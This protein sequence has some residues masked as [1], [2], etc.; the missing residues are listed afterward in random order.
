MIRYKGAAAE[1]YGVRG[2]GRRARELADKGN[3]MQVLY[4]ET[5]RAASAAG[6]AARNGRIENRHL[7]D[8]HGMSVD[9]AMRTL[10][11]YVQARPP[12]PARPWGVERGGPV[13]GSW[14][15]SSAPK[16]KTAAAGLCAALRARAAPPPTSDACRA[17]AVLPPNHV[18]AQALAQLPARVML[19]VI[20]GKGSHSAGNVPLIRGAALHYLRDSGLGHRVVDDNWGAIHVWLGGG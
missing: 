7:V 15:G 17:A 12:P 9:D 5:K 16:N 13:R 20:T 6:F 11:R 1:A 4:K 2:D 18:G 3:E 10:D 8:L 14:D 19:E